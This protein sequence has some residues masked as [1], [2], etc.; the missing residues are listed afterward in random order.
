MSENSLLAAVQAAATN[1]AATVPAASGEGR[2]TQ[3]TTVELAAANEQGRIAGVASERAR[4]GAIITHAEAEGRTQLAHHLAFQTDMT[5]E[6]ASALLA[7]SP[8]AAAAEGNAL[9]EL[10]Q[11]APSIVLGGDVQPGAT[12]GNGPAGASK[13]SGII[14]DYRS[15]TGA[16][17]R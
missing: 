4:I 3:A 9:A 7:M 17:R 13:A 8:K 6:A 14:A 10:R 2:V 5:P 1:P 15:I 11:S 12:G 16:P